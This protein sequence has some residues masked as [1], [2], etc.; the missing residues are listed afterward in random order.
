MKI[1]RIEVVTIPVADQD[2]SKSFYRDILGF[3]VLRDVPMNAQA[4]WIQLAPDGAE[5]SIALVTWVDSLRP[6][7]VKGMVLLTEDIVA[8]HKALSD[9]GVFVTDIKTEPW[10]LFSSFKDPDGNGWIL[11]Q[12]PEA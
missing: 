8:T 1:E 3:V 2:R 10:G 11:R 6:G 4:R 5:T 12:D 7:C 9:R